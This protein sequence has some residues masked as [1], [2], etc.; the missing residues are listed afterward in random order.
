MSD[1]GSGMPRRPSR[2]FETY[3]GDAVYVYMND[4]AQVVL[5]TSD[6]TH[7]TNVIYLESEVLTA[8]DRWIENL[9]AE[10]QN[11]GEG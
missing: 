6:G 2:H 4:V 1:N 8:F 9:M 11:K 10:R 3:L 7:E 5:Y